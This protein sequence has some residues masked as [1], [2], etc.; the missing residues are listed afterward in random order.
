MQTWL[1][2]FYHINQSLLAQLFWRYIYLV[3]IWSITV[4]FKVRW[5]KID[6]AHHGQRLDNFLI[7]K[8][9]TVSKNHIYKII[10]SGQVRV[11]SGRKKPS[12]KL[13]EDDMV[14]IPPVNLDTP[15]STK[16]N[17]YS[18]CQLNTLICFESKDVLVL[19]KPA[20]MPVHS[21]TGNAFGLIEWVKQYES[22]YPYIELA[23]R[24]DRRTSGL[25]ILAKNR[26]TLLYLHDAFKQRAIKKRYILLVHGQIHEAD[27]FVVDQPI[28]I[29]KKSGEKHMAVLEAGKSAKT[30]FKVIRHYEDFTLLFAWPISGRTH[31]IRVHAEHIGHPIVGD[32]KYNML[33]KYQR[34]TAIDASCLFLNASAVKVNTHIDIDIPQE[35]ICPLSKDQRILL[36]QFL[37][38]NA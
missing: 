18:E 11:N 30:I 3:L 19:N 20:G 1:N 17:Y 10:S 16:K 25:I 14:R 36:K 38:A 28:G 29:T 12:Y 37:V 34:E 23:H 7:K 5:V 31:Q 27:K 35:I 22:R 2:G 9:K 33:P 24:I 26:N 15:K 21:G 32:L 13:C 6:A 8:L 4:T